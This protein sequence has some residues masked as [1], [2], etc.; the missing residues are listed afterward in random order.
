MPENDR[1][2]RLRHLLLAAVCTG[3]MAESSFAEH[4]AGA[5]RNATK[6]Q[7]KNRG[8]TIPSHS[9]AADKSEIQEPENAARAFSAVM[10]SSAM[11]VPMD[12]AIAFDSQVSRVPIEDVLEADIALAKMIEQP[13]EASLVLGAAIDG[14]LETPM[15]KFLTMGAALDSALDVMLDEPLDAFQG[16]SAA[17]RAV[18]DASLDIAAALDA[19]LEFPLEAPLQ[20]QAFDAALTSLL[21]AALDGM[22]A[23]GDALDAPLDATLALGASVETALTAALDALLELGAALLDAAMDAPLDASLALGEALDAALTAAIDAAKSLS[24]A[25][26]VPFE[27]ALDAALEVITVLETALTSTIDA[28][29]AIGGSALD[30]P[31]Q[32][33]LD[34]TLDVALT[35]ALAVPWLLPNRKSPFFEDACPTITWAS[36]HDDEHE[37]EIE[38]GAQHRHKSDDGNIKDESYNSG[39]SHLSDDNRHGAFFDDD[40]NNMM[41]GG[42][43]NMF[44]AEVKLDKWQTGAEITLTFDLAV[45]TQ[46][47]VIIY[48]KPFKVDLQGAVRLVDPVDHGAGI[49]FTVQLDRPDRAFDD[50]FLFIGH[51]HY[52]GPPRI[53]CVAQ[54]GRSRNDPSNQYIDEIR[55]IKDVYGPRQGHDVTAKWLTS[56]ARL[57]YPN[58][59]ARTFGL[60][61]NG[62]QFE[63]FRDTSLQSLSA[64]ALLLS[65]SLVIIVAAC[66]ARRRMQPKRRCYSINSV[67]PVESVEAAEA[68][69]LADSMCMASN[70]SGFLPVR[71]SLPNLVLVAHGSRAQNSS[72]EDARESSTLCGEIEEAAAPTS[73]ER[74]D[75]IF[76]L[77]GSGTAANGAALVSQRQ[78]VPQ[79]EKMP[80]AAWDE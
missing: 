40:S 14:V 67:G 39:Y 49:R 17:L 10:S 45:E 51:T 6:V 46:S 44:V 7:R 29:L 63:G 34:A 4:S 48:K 56:T 42:S 64:P 35:I 77:Q 58:Y 19:A 80:L 68:E 25:T 22:L 26:D 43:D 47:T 66:F 61:A 54:H 70:T 12:T 60:G 57:K 3:R 16:F 9:T 18:F 52:L 28:A 5:L 79:N 37:K 71:D 41:S 62:K 59:K 50:A 36:D 75:G 73:A 2:M 23:M 8:D 55:K 15:E 38:E 33:L 13:L 53:E 11:G 31:L 1:M 65:V 69:P 76:P 20:I 74:R 24:T 30:T 27:D 78:H 72:L 21:D 32:V